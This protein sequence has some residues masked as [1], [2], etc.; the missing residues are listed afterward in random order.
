MLATFALGDPDAIRDE[1]EFLL[2][3][4]RFNVMASRA[5]VKLVVFLSREVV[6]HLA[7]DIEVLHGSKLLKVYAETFC[8]NSR[9]MDL[10]YLENG[11]AVIR[12]GAF[13]YK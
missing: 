11:E 7:H 5:R 2:S 1:D 3:L 12:R 4:N 10:G 6:D 13:R 8:A 9:P